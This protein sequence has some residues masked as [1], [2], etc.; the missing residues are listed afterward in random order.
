MTQVTSLQRLLTIMKKLR[1]PQTGCPWDRTQTFDSI[2]PYTLE[3]TYEVLDA[4]QRQDYDDLR[5]ELGDL[6]FQVVFY[7]Q[8]GQ[9]QGLFDFQDICH[10]ISDKL[11]RRH[12]HIFGDASAADTAAVAARWEKIKTQE[13][14]EKALHSALD[15]IPQA[16][17][18][19]MKAHKIQK[20]CAAVG[21]DWNTLGPVVDKVYEEIDEVMHEARQA[22][23]DEKKLEEELGDL[24]FATVNLTRHLGHKAENALQAANRKFE[25]RFRQVEAI[26]GQQGMS[27]NDAT[28]EQ[29]EA[30]WQQVKQQEN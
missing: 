16:L 15:D 3:E 14:A 2:A 5:D 28:L 19:L 6:L 24:L 7:A 10:A 9:E 22:V 11:E 23:V 25:R 27:M 21:F 20:R 4:I 8:M 1:D 29:M 12:P 18:A 17:P 13:R 30:A 26:I